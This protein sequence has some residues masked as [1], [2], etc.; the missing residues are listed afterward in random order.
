MSSRTCNLEHLK[1]KNLKY[2]FNNTTFKMIDK[3]FMCFIML[4][5]TSNKCSYLNHGKKM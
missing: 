4:V 3:Y 2:K 5:N 1:Y